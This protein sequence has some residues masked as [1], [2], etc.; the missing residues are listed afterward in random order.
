MVIVWISVLLDTG[1]IYVKKY[2]LRYTLRIPLMP[3]IKNTTLNSQKTQMY[4]GDKPIKN[5]YVKQPN[6]SWLP[7][8][9]Y[10]WEAGPWG[11]CSASCGGGTQSRLVRCKRSD[12]IYRDDRFCNDITGKPSA[13]QSC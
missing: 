13:I 12:S 5:L 11:S 9:R 8:Y 1:G 10:S 6:G 2:I 7:E 4:V 3:T